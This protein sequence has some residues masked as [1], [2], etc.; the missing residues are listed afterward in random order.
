MTIYGTAKAG[1]SN[2]KDFGVAFGGAADTGFSKA[3]ILAYYQFEES[4]GDLINQA[5]EANGFDDGLGADQDSDVIG[6]DVV[7]GSGVSGII[8]NAYLFDAGSGSYVY[9]NKG[10]TGGI[11][12][13]T[14]DY[15]MNLWLYLDT[16]D[17]ND[18]AIGGFMEAVIFS[19]GTDTY[20][21]GRNPTLSQTTGVTLNQW[22]MFTYTR[23][24]STAN[25][26]FNGSHEATGSNSYS[27]PDSTWMIGG[28]SGF[29]EN[30]HGKIDEFLVANRA[31]TST[32]VTALYNDGAALN[33]LS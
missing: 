12:S 17:G 13:G 4:S 18:L 8:G 21:G 28:K 1:V 25:V 22:D 26:Y 27:L 24:G 15:S 31:L 32:E 33:L 2:T 16:K 5:T 30:Y 9:L 14:G 10:S 20:I 6:G 23:E 11:V 7:R 29:S 19:T 3:G